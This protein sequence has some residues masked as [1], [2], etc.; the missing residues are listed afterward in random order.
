M[1]SADVNGLSLVLFL[2]F[3]EI[4][5][6]KIYIFLLNIF[7]IYRSIIE[8]R[9]DSSW[10]K[11][12]IPIILFSLIS[13]FEIY[14]NDSQRN[15]MLIA[16]TIGISIFHQMSTQLRIKTGGDVFYEMYIAR[17]IPSNQ[18]DLIVCQVARGLD[19]G[20]YLKFN[21]IK[22]PCDCHVKCKKHSFKLKLKLDKEE[23]A[24]DFYECFHIGYTG[25]TKWFGKQTHLEMSIL[26]ELPPTVDC[27]FEF[28]NLETIWVLLPAFLLRHIRFL[29]IFLLVILTSIDLDKNYWTFY[30]FPLPFLNFILLNLIRHIFNE[31]IFKSNPFRLFEICN[32]NGFCFNHFTN[33]YFD[34]NWLDQFVKL[35]RNIF[36]NWKKTSFAVNFTGHLTDIWLGGSELRRV[37]RYNFLR[38]VAL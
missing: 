9:L 25:Y 37:S 12:H 30:F 8:I 26:P 4:V 27:L 6:T 22:L 29:L 35:N 16:K 23:G 15:K 32:Y 34:R 18:W 36:K 5:A 17:K 11:H 21:N 7:N 2:L 33:K 13:M 1:P 3:R 20:K 14:G 28:F 24:E 10:I 38:P 31:I 19:R